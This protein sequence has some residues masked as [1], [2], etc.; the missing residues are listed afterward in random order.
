MEEACNGLD[1]SHNTLFST[2]DNSYGA[3]FH[4]RHKK[5]GI[6]TKMVFACTYNNHSL[7][8]IVGIIWLYTMKS[9]YI[10]K[11]YNKSYTLTF[12]VLLLLY[13][14]TGYVGGSAPIACLV[15]GL[16][17]G[18]TKQV[19]GMF[20]LKTKISVDV[21]VQEFNSLITFFVN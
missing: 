1:Y 12:A 7:G 11:V 21:K 4:A 2:E 10:Q 16:I 20:K 6:L 14:G 19:A 15:F 8:F 18:N 5:T 9:T 13:A 17:L 3:G